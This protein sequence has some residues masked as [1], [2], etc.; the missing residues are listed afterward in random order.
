MTEHQPEAPAVPGVT[1][2]RT[3]RTVPGV[4]REAI[5]LMFGNLAEAGTW[6]RSHGQE[7]HYDGTDLLIGTPGDYIRAIPGEW[8]VRNPDSSWGFGHDV[9][10]AETFAET[11]EPAPGP[12]ILPPDEFRAVQVVAAVLGVPGAAPEP[13]GPGGASTTP[14]QARWP[15]TAS[16]LRSQVRAA[17]E[18]WVSGDAGDEDPADVVMGIVAPFME[19]MTAEGLRA[20]TDRADVAEAKLCQIAAYVTDNPP[21]VRVQFILGIIGSEKGPD[22]G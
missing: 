1:R 10:P 5:R 3:P 4:E 13:D 21:P 14:F 7:C 6:V 9:F 8:I 2:W 22:H 11:Y 15:V 18:Y 20:E 12:L 16:V 19:S 17:I